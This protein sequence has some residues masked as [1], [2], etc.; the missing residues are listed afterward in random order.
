VNATLRDYNRIKAQYQGELK[1]LQD[2]CRKWRDQHNGEL[3]LQSQIPDK[4]FKTYQQ[5][6][7]NRHLMLV[8]N[9]LPFEID[10]FQGAKDGATV[11]PHA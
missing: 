7:Q 3:P 11:Q 9:K 4:I 10:Q 8:Q 1:K 6:E 2:F 5:H